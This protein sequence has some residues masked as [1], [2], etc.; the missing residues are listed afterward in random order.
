VLHA[1]LA[2]APAPGW[3][4]GLRYASG[5]WRLGGR[6]QLRYQ[7]VHGFDFSVGLGLSR[8][9]YSFPV[10]DVLD[11]LGLDAF[12]RTGIDVP[13]L[14][15]KR[16]RWYRVWGGGR[17]DLSHFS[18]ALRLALPAT[19]GTPAELVAASVDGVGT[20]LVF[21]GGAAIG[22]A[23]VFL[24]FELSAARLFSGARLT[25]AGVDHD[26]DLGGLIVSPGFALL[27]EF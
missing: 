22:F 24:G 25:F 26:V 2:F 15:G 20:L 27:G 10:V 13:V 18:G 16:T 7:E 11:Y 12:T 4:L 21:Q 23:H 8:H 19:G 1:A 6:T 3:E 14:V 5:G 9:T 17:L